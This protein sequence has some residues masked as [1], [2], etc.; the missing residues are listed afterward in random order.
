[1]CPDLEYVGALNK[2]SQQVNTKYFTS[3]KKGFPYEERIEFYW[4][5]ALNASE[6][7][8]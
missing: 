5:Y 4:K 6:L 1:M 2:T 8:I 3:V 7:S